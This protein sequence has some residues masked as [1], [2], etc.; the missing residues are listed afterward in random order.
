MKKAGIIIA[1]VLCA[2][3]VLLAQDYKGKGRLNGIVVDQEGKPIP[4][5]TIKAYS[6][7]YKGGFSVK[8]EKDGKW[9][10]P[11]I[12][13]GN[14]DLDFYKVGYEPFKTSAYVQE[15]TRN[16]DMKIVMKK[17]EGI[18]LTDELKNMLVAANKLFDEKK[19]DEA[20]A[21]YNQI[22]TKFP[23]VYII[24]RN[25]GNCYFVQEKYDQAEEAYKKVLE[26]N[27]EDTDALLGIGN[28]YF[29]RNQPD[30]ASE[31]YNK[32]QFEKIYDP[33]VLFNIG[34]NYFKSSKMEDAVRYF[35]RSTEV[36]KN[37]E[38]GYYQLG[39]TYT[40]M[41]QK[42]DA[43]AVFEQFLKLFPDSPR[44]DQVKAFLDYLKK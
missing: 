30:K 43:I 13:I 1:C 37:F 20:M 19:F 32:I 6:V 33:A 36:D 7:E 9:V 5:V 42:A 15:L 27:A 3:G 11:W 44:K 8:S 34:L 40:N 38:D 10:V 26:K 28:C 14:W 12:R 31:Y 22:L 2:T 23:E 18:A 29:N 25:I 21:G 39:L 35:K 4:E 24:W 41:M 16:P 17:M